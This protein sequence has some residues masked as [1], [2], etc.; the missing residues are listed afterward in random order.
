M[1]IKASEVST[2]KTAK[3]AVEKY[4]HDVRVKN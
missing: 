2:S 3:N 1:N 4:V